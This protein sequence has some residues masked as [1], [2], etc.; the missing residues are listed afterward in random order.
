MR[1]IRRFKSGAA[2]LRIGNL[3]TVVHSESSLSSLP[4]SLT[5]AEAVRSCSLTAAPCKYVRGAAVELPD[6]NLQDKLVSLTRTA[7]AEALLRLRARMP[8]RG[9]KFPD[10]TLI[11][12]KALRIGIFGS[13]YSPQRGTRWLGPSLVAKD[14]SLT[15]AVLGKS[16]VHA[17]WPR[18]D[19]KHAVGIQDY[20]PAINP[21]VAV[22][23]GYGRFVTGKLG[24]RAE[25]VLL[26]TVYVPTRLR[27]VVTSTYKE[28][29]VIASPLLDTYEEKVQ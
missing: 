21:A 19:G 12:I 15:A 5:A 18:R 29:V 17:M 10:G 13:L 22:V 27:R 8:L 24:W 4:A 20:L 1:V 25:K 7:A 16:G 14:F 9:A 23:A 6:Y 28:V 3:Y 11:G 2:L 26:Q